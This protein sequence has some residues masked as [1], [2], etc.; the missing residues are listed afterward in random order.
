MRDVRIYVGTGA[1]EG[2]SEDKFRELL[3]QHAGGTSD[4]VKRFS[5]RECYSFVDVAEEAADEVVEK[6]GE[7]D[8][9]GNKLLLKKAVTINVPRPVEQMDRESD[10]DSDRG[11]EMDNGADTGG[12]EEKGGNY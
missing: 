10:M 1:K 7:L 9:Q 3:S 4:K 6:L 11:G 5:Q 8:Y 2:L 12:V